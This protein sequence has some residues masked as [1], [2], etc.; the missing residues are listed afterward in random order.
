MFELTTHV[1]FIIMFSDT[2]RHAASTCQAYYQ[3]GQVCCTTDAAQPLQRRNHE[4]IFV[5]NDGVLKGQAI[6]ELGDVGN[7]GNGLKRVL[8]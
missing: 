1:E 7:S 4:R 5:C 6:I 8:G 2:N 3:I